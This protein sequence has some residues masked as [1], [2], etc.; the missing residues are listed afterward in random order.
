M[1]S[2]EEIDDAHVL[3]RGGSTATS[4]QLIDDVVRSS[5][6]RPKIIVDCSD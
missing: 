5:T 6:G 3:R 1:E 4:R 2:L